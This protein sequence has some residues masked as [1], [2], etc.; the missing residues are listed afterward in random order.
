MQCSV[1]QESAPDCG[2]RLW[3][4]AGHVLGMEA[5]VRTTVLEQPRVEHAPVELSTVSTADMAVDA[6]LHLASN[7]RSVPCKKRPLCWYKPP[8]SPGGPRSPPS[9]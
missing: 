3:D 2:S 6:A 8:V 4:Q 7:F 5:G 9:K 1:A